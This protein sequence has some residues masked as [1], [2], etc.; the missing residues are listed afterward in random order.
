[1]KIGDLA[2]KA[3]VSVDTLRY[4]EKI[5]LLSGVQRTR[6]GYRSYS[7]HNVEQVKFIR[8]AQH[9]GFSLDEITHLLSFR[10]APV[11]AKP[12]VRKLAEEKVLDLSTRID[13]LVLLRDELNALIDQCAKSD[14]YCP[15]IDNFN[16]KGGDGFGKEV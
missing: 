4:Y 2:K 14:A 10:N 16:D 11:E 8:N 12:K 15:I 5:G 7:Q 1:M 6:S 13:A 9:S 3:N